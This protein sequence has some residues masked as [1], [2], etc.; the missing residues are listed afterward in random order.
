MFMWLS[1]FHILKSCCHAPLIYT[2][3]NAF[4]YTID[5]GLCEA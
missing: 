5:Y 3:K 4:V 2:S 1:F